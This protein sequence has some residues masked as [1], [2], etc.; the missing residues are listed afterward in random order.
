MLIFDTF[1]SEKNFKETKVIEIVKVLFLSF[2]NPIAFLFPESTI[3]PTQAFILFHIQYS[4]LIHGFI[5][6]CFSYPRSNTCGSRSSLHSPG[7]LSHSSRSFYLPL[8]R[9]TS[10]CL[11]SI[12]LLAECLF[13][14]SLI[15]S[16]SFRNCAPYT[17]NRV[18]TQFSM[19]VLGSSTQITSPHLSPFVHTSSQKPQ[20]AL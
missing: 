2:P 16:L 6:Y 19:T 10:I 12:Y 5:F 11:I 13:I 15:K 14:T 18:L 17:I 1:F 4:P 8:K 20:T 9:K 3:I 7:L